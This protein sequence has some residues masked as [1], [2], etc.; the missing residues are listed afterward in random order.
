MRAKSLALLNGGNSVDD[1]PVYLVNGSVIALTGVDAAAHQHF[2]NSLSLVMVYGEIILRQAQM[3]C[4]LRQLLNDTLT[5][6]Q[7]VGR[8][9]D[10]ER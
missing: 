1:K 5:Q 7:S 2:V 3:P 4:Q 8:T 9:L 10:V 6:V